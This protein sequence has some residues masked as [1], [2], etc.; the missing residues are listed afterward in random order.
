MYACQ[1]KETDF[2]CFTRSDDS[3]IDWISYIHFKLRQNL[4]RSKNTE[5]IG[6]KRESRFSC[7]YHQREISL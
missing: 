2:D 7:K 5:C 4:H 1:G 3:F 6:G